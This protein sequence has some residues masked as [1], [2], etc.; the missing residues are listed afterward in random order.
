MANLK[1]DL[2]S[3]ES[4]KVDKALRD[5]L[6]QVFTEE[7]KA[8]L[9]TDLKRDFGIIKEEL[10]PSS[11]LNPT[12]NVR[13]LIRAVSGIAAA[14]IILI[15]S[16]F[17]IKSMQPGIQEMASQ[18]AMLEQ[19]IHPGLTKG[20]ADLEAQ[21]REAI[22]SFNNKEWEN[23][24]SLFSLVEPATAE[25]IYYQGVSLFMAAKYIEAIE[26]LSNNELRESVYN[27]EATWYIGLSYILN[28]DTDEGL[29][30]LRT[31]KPGEW[32]YEEAQK[33]ISK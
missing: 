31:I 14:V 25:I 13:R 16:Y 5:G 19:P 33:L 24:A 9:K 3:N 21:F 1:N 32:K 8:E 28:G 17:V 6:H 23:A 15:A 4:E 10:Q 22:S 30:I 11:K 7:L 26:L 20:A 27:Q 2:N 18:F 12:N 29:E